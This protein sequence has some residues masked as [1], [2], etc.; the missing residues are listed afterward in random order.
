M[1]R[2]NVL[3]AGCGHMGTSHARAYH[4]MEEFNIVGLVSRSPASRERLSR[5]LGGYPTFAPVRNGIAGYP[6]G[7]RICQYVPR[8]TCR[9]RG[10]KPP[11]RRTRICRKA[12]WPP[13][14]RMHKPLAELA[15]ATNRKLVIGYILR[16]HPAWKEFIRIAQTLGKPLVMRMNLNQQSSGAQWET[17]KALMHSMSPI[18][19]CG[20]H[21]VGRHV[22][23]DAL[24]PHPR[25]RHRCA[26]LRGDCSLHV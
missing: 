17:H 10:P 3:V 11:Q 18:V 1:S 12:A 2:L 21:Y 9:L 13:L 26:P 4:A 6:T 19:D 8:Y 23:D 25:Q 24:N 22:P 15:A 5:E 16:V 20:V 14:W 7:C